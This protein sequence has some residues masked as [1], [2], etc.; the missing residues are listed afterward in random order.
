LRGR[1]V[2]EG[3]GTWGV[4][5]AEDAE[6]LETAFEDVDEFVV[7]VGVGGGHEEA[8]AEDVVVGVGDDAF[9]GFAVVEEDADPEALHDGCVLVEVES[10]VAEVAVEGHDEEDGLGVGGGD[11]LDLSG[12][13]GGEANRVEGVLGVVAEELIDGADFAGGGEAADGMILEAD[14]DFIGGWCSGR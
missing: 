14:D 1:R 6:V 11:L 3:G 12:F 5:E 7:A 9:D 2:L 13:D 4:A 10:A 8:G